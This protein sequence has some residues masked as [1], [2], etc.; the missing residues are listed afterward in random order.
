MSRTRAWTRFQRRR[1]IGR[2]IGFLRRNYGEY[3]VECWTRGKPGALSKG[4]I[5]CSCWM[6]RK[7]SYD[8]ASIPDRRILDGAK[9]ALDDM[10]AT[11]E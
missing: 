5:H 1:A 6:C 4:K 11:N 9:A 7:K 10:N 8:E 2:K 3:E